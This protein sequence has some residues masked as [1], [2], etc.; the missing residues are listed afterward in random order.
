[1]YLAIFII[2]KKIY[3]YNDNSCSNKS[4]KILVF[5]PKKKGIY[6]IELRQV[7]ERKKT[8]PT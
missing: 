6:S 8:Y 4:L 3:C 5:Q 1:M 2:L 7:G